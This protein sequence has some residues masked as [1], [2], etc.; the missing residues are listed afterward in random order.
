[1]ARALNDKHID[2]YRAVVTYE[3]GTRDYGTDEFKTSVG[4]DGEIMRVTAYRGPYTAVGVASS[5]GNSVGREYR[6]RRVIEKRIQRLTPVAFE[7]IKTDQFG[8]REISVAAEL[9]WIDV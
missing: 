7:T 8:N 3:Y 5:V 4:D 9:R 2:F 6:S 1:M